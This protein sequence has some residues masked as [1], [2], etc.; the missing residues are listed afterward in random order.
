MADNNFNFDNLDKLPQYKA[1]F[2]N[3]RTSIN[4]LNTSIND[5][6]KSQTKYNKQ[7][8]ETVTWG[9]KIKNTVKDLVGTFD[10]TP[11]LVLSPTSS[12]F[13]QLK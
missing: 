10:T 13:H 9:T 3:L 2:D 12:F 6:E 4:S 11:L 1:A 7:N 5:L 8:Q